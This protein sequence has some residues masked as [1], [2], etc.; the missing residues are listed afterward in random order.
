MLFT[1][2]EGSTKLL[3]HLGPECYREVLDLHRRLLRN[4]F[5]RHAG[6][7]VDAEGDAFFVAF[8]RAQDA[9][10]AAAAGQRALAEAD[11]P[12]DRR[13]RVRMGVHTGEPLAA[14]P[15]YVGL[16]VHRTARIMAAGHG[17]QVLVS[18]ATKE[19]VVD[20]SDSFHDLGYH[21]LKDLSAAQRLYQLGSAPFPPLKSLGL[22]NLPVQPLPLVG[23]ARELAEALELLRA[24]RLLTFTGAGGSG[25]TRLALQVAAEA[26]ESYPDG[27][28]FV[29]LAS[30]TDP[31][32]VESAIAGVLGDPDDL[33]A[34]LA[35]KRLLLLLDNLEQL[36]PRVAMT[37]ARL[38]EA[39]EV[40][41]L[42]T[43]RERLAVAAEQEY[44]VPTLA[45]DEASALFVA[46]ARRLKPK[47][48]PDDNVTRIVARLDGL[49]L[50]VELA[51]ARVKVLTTGQILV[52]LGQS[53]DLLTTGAADAPTRQQTLR[54]AI[55]WSYELVPREER[56]LF[57][58][59]GVFA[60]S[61]DLEAAE[62][63]AGASIDTLGSLVDKNLL[64]Q[65]DEGRF[66]MLETIREFAVERLEAG[67]STE[68]RDR[69]AHVAIGRARAPQRDG[70]RQWREAIRQ[71][72]ADFRAALEWLE[73]TDSKAFTT[74]V[75]S[76]ASYW[77]M[78]GELNEGTRWLETM[79]S[80]SAE[81]TPERAWARN[82]YVQLLRSKRDL[83]RARAEN[84][85]VQSEARQL[86]DRLLQADAKA[87]RGAV[88]YVDGNLEEAAAEYEKSIALL[89]ALE[90]TLLVGVMQH[91]LGIVALMIGDYPRARELLEKA[92][93]TAVAYTSSS[94]EANV[95]GSLGFLELEEHHAEDALETF[96]SA[97]RA[98]AL[99]GAFGLAA[100]TDAYGLAAALAVHGDAAA[101]QLLVAALDEYF[102]GIGAIPEPLPEK[103]RSR[104]LATAGETL[105]PDDADAAR[106]RGRSMTPEEA[107]A[108]VAVA[109]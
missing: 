16:D 54:A 100:A 30:L 42:A 1:D 50:A 65:T 34:F 36:L 52:R 33:S 93:A 86:G 45:P 26:I 85:R 103:A 107:I 80:R 12:G 7:E 75:S 87:H 58:R 61:F 25:K 53:L 23:R 97:L 40:T 109:V 51:A 37:V 31:D 98:H 78:Q 14:P 27:V 35:S 82:T 83:H 11:W 21:R 48:V 90:E 20:G 46:R 68:V 8:S 24:N 18:Q 99:S 63:V 104:V 47:F 43:S 96:R 89:Q 101:A 57:A 66:F 22:T 88:E 72:Y 59:L 94:L 32:L 60:G 105:S 9:I 69:H 55:E 106:A 71:D 76:L 41:I 13:I 3:E 102:R 70:R 64:R 73:G 4:A 39:A 62:R 81:V 95:L 84:D 67:N 74:L 29:S 49:P 19:L 38:L 108:A 15:K 44:P 92:R 28:W 6:Y 79:L 91:D 56:E 5:S 10:A 77:D 2:I 17:G